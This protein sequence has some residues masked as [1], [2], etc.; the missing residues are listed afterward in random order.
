MLAR[1]LDLR[2]ATN[3]DKLPQEL[4][5][6]PQWCVAGPDENGKFRVPNTVLGNRL[7]K[8][9]PTDPRSWGDFETALE[10]AEANPA[11]GLGFVLSA[12]DNFVCIDLDIKNAH[13]ETDP[14]KWTG[15]DIIAR[16][17]QIIEAFGS[18]TERSAS[19]QGYHIW[20]RGNI[21]RGVRRDS[22]EVYSQERFIVCTG[23]VYKDLPICE[24]QRLLDLLTAEMRKGEA[25][26]LALVDKEQ[27]EK[28]ETIFARAVAAENSSKFISLCEGSW[29]EL[30][31]PSQSEADA[32]LLTM[33]AFYTKS[34]SQVMRLF[35]ATH[36]GKRE[37]A[38]RNDYYLLTSLAKVRSIAA[39]EDASSAHG[40]SIAR[41]LM[42]RMRPPAPVA[43]PV[44]AWA[45][46]PPPVA[47]VAA[48]G[49]Q[50]NPKHP[51]TRGNIGSLGLPK[52]LPPEDLT[53]DIP[54]R[55]ASELP[56]P[57]GFV[58]EVAEY[59]FRTAPRPV[60]EVAIVAALGLFAGICGKSYCIQQSGLNLYI[61][62]VGQSGIGKEAMHSGISN[63]LH[64]ISQASPE[65]TNFVDFSEYVSA[66]A[67]TK[68]MVNFPSFVNVCG[69][70]GK[71][72]KRMSDD[73][74]GDSGIAQLRTALTNM[75][76]K[77]GPSSM[78]G[79]LGYSDKEKNA[80]SVSG[81]AYSMIGETTPGTLY[82]SLTDS[83]M[84]DGF[85]SRFT[86]VEYSGERPVANRNPDLRLSDAM[87]A[88]FAQLCKLSKDNIDAKD[89][90]IFVEYSNDAA[91]FFDHF[92][93]KCD[94]QINSTADEGWRQMW[95][96]AHLKV[97]RIASLLAVAD[98]FHAPVVELHH[99]TWAYDLIMRDIAIMMRRVQSGDVG[100]SD[101]TRESKI[102]SLA[103][104]WLTEEIPASLNISPEMKNVGVVTRKYFQIS[105]QRTSSFTSHKLGQIAA[106][107]MTLRSLVASGYFQEVPKVEAIQRFNF[108]G[109]C[110]RILSL[111]SSA[112]QTASP[113][114]LAASK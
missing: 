110:F 88:R 43:A 81:A 53:D 40:E 45:T 4:C 35:R 105:T 66:P 62:L 68:A 37:K 96:R 72:L 21:G 49:A 54:K 85:L 98:N 20:L 14:S 84:A 22:V 100:L 30:G 94:K 55:N 106:L 83:M 99:A 38:V 101:A 114:S 29:L 103:K 112:V 13:N 47:P 15:P 16:H 48:V 64:R 42:Q 18:Y 74:R 61:I 93:A 3:Y 10:F 50:A 67:L 109:A 28:D 39:K 82:D 87:I 1:S 92:D 9:D 58:G 46:L 12:K 52:L 65:S 76:Q 31:Y 25:P 19:G 107:D 27:T 17:H 63:I 36:L 24:N 44:P 51:A 7:R 6:T 8:A 34:N 26:A 78:L 5:W 2:M 97:L 80:V 102:L 95:N 75:Y 33:F 113:I 89:D 70:F 69:E 90:S 41:A 59:I 86:I 60:R 56:Y 71:K 79:G 77:S 11:C 32:A 73:E 57:P 111:P 23:D 104:S 91:N 108:H